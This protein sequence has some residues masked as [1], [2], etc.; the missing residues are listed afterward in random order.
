MMGR[1]STAPE[2][3][4]AGDGTETFGVH[5]VLD[6]DDEFATEQWLAYDRQDGGFAWREYPGDSGCVFSDHKVAE[7]VV[8]AYRLGYEDAADRVRIVPLG[9]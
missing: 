4:Y 3:R 8:W 1:H 7:F 2:V 9:S 5:R 6:P